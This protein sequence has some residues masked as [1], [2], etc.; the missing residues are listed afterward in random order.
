MSFKI[1]F[2]FNSKFH[3]A[4]FS[5]P[6]DSFNYIACFMVPIISRSSSSAHTYGLTVHQASMSD[7][8]FR[9]CVVHGVFP[10]L[11]ILNSIAYLVSLFSVLHADS[12]NGTQHDHLLF[13][14]NKKNWKIHNFLVCR[15]GQIQK[16]TYAVRTTF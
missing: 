10:G 12:E 13:S 16:Y 8:K 15:I 6:N 14:Q 9:L 7:P 3:W 2:N 5:T 11:K 1:K 4:W